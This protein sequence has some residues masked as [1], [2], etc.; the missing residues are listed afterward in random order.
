[1][2]LRIFLLSS[3]FIVFANL[4]LSAQ[5]N[6]RSSDLADCKIY[7]KDGSSRRARINEYDLIGRNKI[8][9]EEATELETASIDYV[10]LDSISYFIKSVKSEMAKPIIV[11]ERVMKGKI[12]FYVSPRKGPNNY[13]Y[14]EKDGSFFQMR[15][16]DRTIRDGSVIVVDEFKSI[17][18]SWLLD[19]PLM[20]GTT[21]T[22]LKLN[23]KSLMTFFESYN[24]HCGTL[25]SMERHP[26]KRVPHAIY[27]ASVGYVNT[28][29][30]AAFEK[31]GASD[32]AQGNP[33]GY[34]FGG[35]MKINFEKNTR[36][37]L[38]NDLLFE[39]L[40]G[41]AGVSFANYNYDKTLVLEKSDY[42][43]H[44]DVQEV[45][46][47]FAFGWVGFVRNRFSISAEGG[48]LFQ[49]RVSNNS[50]YQ[51]IHSSSFYNYRTVATGSTKELSNYKALTFSPT[52]NLNFTFGD[53]TLRCQYAGINVCDTG[54]D[55]SGYSKRVWLI[56][57][58]QRK[59][60]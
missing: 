40:T 13:F 4:V 16:V 60:K 1:M 23:Y 36:T 34:F 29:T 57:Y 53:L 8:Y 21:L 11:V 42:S 6:L 5:G 25:E 46:D 14:A 49:Y 51:I 20:G 30:G 7:F 3:L 2:R 58:F 18:K 35:S 47:H 15:K 37:F 10:E 22:N 52:V 27:G 9:I 56:Y 39:H 17:L 19:C 32:P 45:S 55:E 54:I 38:T 12:S 28:L 44:Y 48:M 43:L 41:D 31:I 59:T 24:T 26:P 50:K 33:T